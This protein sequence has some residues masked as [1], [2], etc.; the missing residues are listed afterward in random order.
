[1]RSDE[2]LVA[3]SKQPKNVNINSH[4]AWE[5]LRKR[6]RLPG[7]RHAEIVVAIV[8]PVVVDVETVGI[9]VANVDMVAVRVEILLVSICVTEARG[10]LPI[11]LYPLTSEFNTGATLEYLQKK[12]ARSS[13]PFL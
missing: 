10:L 11:G 6:E 1:M 12:Q 3:G 13:I 2:C 5:F 4:R 9:E 8:V 7:G